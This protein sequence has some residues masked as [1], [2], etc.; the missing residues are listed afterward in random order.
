MEENEL[1]SSTITG[2]GALLSSGRGGEEVWASQQAASSCLVVVP[3]P[4]QPP[5]QPLCI[6]SGCGPRWRSLACPDCQ[7]FNLGSLP[8]AQALQVGEG[9]AEGPLKV[10]LSNPL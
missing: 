9:R 4:G 5:Y 8:L 3:S 6:T 10:L 2:E 7:P 1:Y